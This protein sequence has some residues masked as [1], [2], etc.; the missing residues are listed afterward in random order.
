VKV[1]DGLTFLFDD[2]PEFESHHYAF[3]VS[4]PEFDAIFHRVQEGGLTYGSAPWS[5]EDGKLNA[6]ALVALMWSVA[7][8]AGF[9]HHLKESGLLQRYRLGSSPLA[10]Q[11]LGT[12]AHGVRRAASTHVRGVVRQSACVG[13]DRVSGPARAVA[14]NDTVTIALPDPVKAGVPHSIAR[15]LIIKNLVGKD[16]TGRHVLT[17]LGRGVLQ[18]LIKA[19]I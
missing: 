3:H 5:L 6:F 4:D 11:P 1:N 16:R 14:M 12:A 9:V 17:E 8:G 15:V 13:V 19:G 7:L 2:D 10:G 18:S